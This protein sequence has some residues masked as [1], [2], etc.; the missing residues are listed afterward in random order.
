MIS[1]KPPLKETVYR[2]MREYFAISF[3]LWVVFAAF[4]VHKSIVLAEHKI[5]FAPHGIALINA[6]ASA[7]I[8]LLAEHFHL[9]DRF[10]YKPLIYPIL[11]KSAAF[12][13]LVECFKFLEE[14]ALGAYHGKSVKASILEIGG[15]TVTGIVFLTVLLFMLLI[16]F[17]SYRELKRFFGADK[18][19][20]ILFQ[21]RSSA[22]P[23]S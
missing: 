20:M 8:I 4:T 14:I 5:D 1:P 6:L 10:R 13:V 7:K 19:K 17:F 9:A 16:P 2:E 21:S 3:Y 11:F 23:D 18:L 15:G 22:N 12:T